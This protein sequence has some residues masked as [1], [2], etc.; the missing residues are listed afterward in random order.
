VALRLSSAQVARRG[1]AGLRAK[2]SLASNDVGVVSDERLSAM[3][4]LT[5]NASQA[6]SVRGDP[7]R[8]AFGDSQRM[9]LDAA[10]TR[11]RAKTAVAS[12][13]LLH[14][15]KEGCVAHLACSLNSSGALAVLQDDER[16]IVSNQRAV[17]AVRCSTLVAGIAT[18]YKVL[19]R[20]IRRIVIE[21]V[22][23]ERAGSETLSGHPLHR[24]LAPVAGMGAGADL[25]IE[26]YTANRYAA[27]RRC[28]W[29]PWCSEHSMLDLVLF[30]PRAVS[31]SVIALAR[32]KTAWS[33]ARPAWQW[34]RHT[35]DLAKTVVG[36]ASRALPRSARLFVHVS[37]CITQEVS[38]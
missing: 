13:Y 2:A 4:A 28:Y 36:S 14:A 5:L 19:R 22:G 7:H 35:A 8:V 33:T 31:R 21:M 18:W 27:R 17:L 12:R 38:T 10:G 15:S 1:G 3:L 6:L 23:N 30:L 20:V 29:V 32:A 16:L 9:L 25:V 37:K 26:H 11:T 34:K 24:S